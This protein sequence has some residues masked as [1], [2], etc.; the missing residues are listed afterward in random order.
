MGN[1]VHVLLEAAAGRADEPVG[2]V[3]AR[4]KRFTDRRIKQLRPDLSDEVWEVGY[5]DRYVR[6]GKLPV[7]FDYV[8]DN[9]RKA[10]LISDGRDWPFLWVP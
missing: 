4:H 7:V 9:P 8:V 6:P 2:N 3:V 5:F 1:H 10:G